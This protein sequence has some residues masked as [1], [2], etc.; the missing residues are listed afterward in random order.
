MALAPLVLLP[1]SEGKAAGGRG[2]PWQPGSIAFPE[3]DEARAQVMASLSA[4]MVSPEPLRAKLLG[5]KGDALAAATTAN[6]SVSTA[7]TRATIDRYT[8]V[9]YDALD[10][11]TLPAV[12]R[13]RLNRQVIIFSGVF[14]ATR[15]G[16]RIPDHKLKMSAGLAPM[17]TLAT[18]WRRPLTDAM[19]SSVQRRMV[20]NL[21][22]LEHDAAWAP[23]EAGT[24]APG[25]PTAVVSV[26]FLDE[27]PRRP[28]EVR[29]FTSVS[30]WNKLLKGALVR[31]VLA[32]GADEPDALAHFEHPLGYRYDPSL[33]EQTKDRTQIAMVRPTP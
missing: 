9:L 22:P 21:L 17:G 25:A 12:S 31:H 11:A 8:G 16:D 29:T 13:R 10:A 15:P 26:R 7:P 30:H 1:P 23:P 14:G 2:R 20:W 19:A 4:A 24:A 27:K 5:V 33:T 6:S 32:T 18:W 3:L 28:G